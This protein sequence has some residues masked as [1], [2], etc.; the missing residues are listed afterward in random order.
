MKKAI[1]KTLAVVALASLSAASLAQEV[2]E[3]SIQVIGKS[4]YK[5]APQEFETYA[6]TYKLETGQVLKLRGTMNHYFVQLKGEPE[7]EMV[8][9]AP[10]VFVASTGTR[11]DFRDDGDLVLVTGVERLPIASNGAT[12]LGQVASR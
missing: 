8:G 4:G 9:Q 5:L 12:S 11:L 2:A 10:G 1:L 6:R 7:V 3:Q